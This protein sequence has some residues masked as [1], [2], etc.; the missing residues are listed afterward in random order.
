MSWPTLPGSGALTID[1]DFTVASA[2]NFLQG[3]LANVA[4][5]Q[6][7]FALGNVTTAP[8]SLGGLE[9]GVFYVESGHFKYLGSQGTVTTVA[10]A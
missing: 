4:S 3:A 6:V 8:S 7:V 2:H 1:G 9:G 5:G 10:S